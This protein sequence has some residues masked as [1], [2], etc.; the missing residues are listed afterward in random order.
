MTTGVIQVNISLC[1]V[2]SNIYLLVPKTEDLLTTSKDTF[3]G[4]Q[5]AVNTA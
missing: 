1:C 2:G 4:P 3:Q 5:T